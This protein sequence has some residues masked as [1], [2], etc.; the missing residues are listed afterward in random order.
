MC[1]PCLSN[2]SLGYSQGPA[3]YRLKHVLLWCKT[4]IFFLLFFFFFSFLKYVIFD[5]MGLWAFIQFFYFFIAVCSTISCYWG[6]LVWWPCLPFYRPISPGRDSHSSLQLRPWVFVWLRVVVIGIPTRIL[7]HPI[8][9]PDPFISAT[10]ERHTVRIN[11]ARQT[12]FAVP[13]IGDG[14]RREGC[15]SDKRNIIE[16]RWWGY[17]HHIVFGWIFSVSRCN[18]GIM[19]W[20]VV[21]PSFVRVWKLAEGGETHGCSDGRIDAYNTSLLFFWHY[22]K[23]RDIRVWEIEEVTWQNYSFSSAGYKMV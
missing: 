2:R 23:V 4:T 8:F 21:S 5:N 17:A 1:G 20:W 9:S 12:G 19:S 13:G 6:V 3:I 22:P 18:K 15:H 7:P 16:G 14:S 11:I 10:L